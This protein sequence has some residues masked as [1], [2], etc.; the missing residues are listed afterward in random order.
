MS[1][2]I[3]TIFSLVVPVIVSPE[4]EH[5]V[6]TCRELKTPTPQV[7]RIPIDGIINVV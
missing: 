7:A 2:Q 3:K 6:L 1:L 5:D 4:A